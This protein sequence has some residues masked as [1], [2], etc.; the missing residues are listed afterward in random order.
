MCDSTVFLLNHHT[1]IQLG[2][3]KKIK[4]KKKDDHRF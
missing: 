2:E 4:G 3:K 1:I